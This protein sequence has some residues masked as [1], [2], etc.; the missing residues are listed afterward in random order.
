LEIA[1]RDRGVYGFL[2]VLPELLKNTPS[3][4]QLQILLPSGEIFDVKLLQLSPTGVALISIASGAHA[5]TGTP[6]RYDSDPLEL[7]TIDKLR[8]L[9]EDHL[10]AEGLFNTTVSLQANL[11]ESLAGH[12]GV[13]NFAGS[14]DPLRVKDVLNRLIP[15]LQKRFRL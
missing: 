8:S 7:T 3:A 11:D 15:E 12:W 13:K 9:V 10:K 6:L 1:D 2:T 5:D 14:D 4:K